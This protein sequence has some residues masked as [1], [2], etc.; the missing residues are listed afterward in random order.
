MYETLPMKNKLDKGANLN[1]FVNRLISTLGL[2]SMF[3]FF[4]SRGWPKNFQMQHVYNGLKQL[5]R[6]I[7]GMGNQVTV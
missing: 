7:L 1:N 2:L 3:F 4:S 5:S 6:W